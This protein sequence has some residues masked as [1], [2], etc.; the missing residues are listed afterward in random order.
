M[1]QF[2]R[3]AI[4]DWHKYLED[5][6]NSTPVE[7][8]LTHAEMEKK[9][10]YLEA[11]PIEW[12][13]YFFPK[14]ASAE[15]AP[16]QKRAIN[17]IL[18]NPE[19]YEVLSW[20]RELAKSTIAMF[21]IMFLVL[22]GRKHCVIILSATWDNAVK[23]LGHY[24]ANFEANGRI[25][26]FYGTQ[27]TIGHWEKDNLTL[28]NGT[29]FIAIGA[30][31]MP[32][33][34]RSEN[35]RPDI[36]CMDDYDTDEDCRNPETLKKKWDFFEDAVYPTRSVSVNTLILWLGNIIAKDCCI[37]RAG[38]MADNWDIINIRD[39]SGNS[40]W[41]E[42]NTEK[43]IDR[44]LSGI[45][46]AAQQKEYY[47]NPI[48]EGMIFKEMVF[49]KVPPLRKFKFLVIYGDPAPSES[50]KKGTSFKSVW[51]TGFHEG[52][53]YVIKGF[54]DHCLSTEFIYHYVSLLEYVDNK[55]VV[56][57]YMENNKLQDPFFQQVFRPIVLK[58]RKEKNISLYIAPDIE[59]KTD[60]ATR[61]EANL[62]PLNREGALIFNEDEKDN[63]NMQ[64]LRDQFQLFEM[65]L[66]YAADGPDSIEGAQR[67]LRHKRQTM[68]PDI[69]IS[70]D[71]L[72]RKNKFRI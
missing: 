31:N 70:R 6:M 38:K 68:E 18:S 12:I 58:I 25:K 32:R 34:A 42:K 29:S 55:S 50:K 49:G 54:L 66:P 23:L 36:I 37:A 27:Q 52:K 9:R 22:T 4:Q 39:K 13:K 59:R 72:T 46:T 53:L 19:W 28:K 64:E 30:G 40:S 65:Y 5:I 56:Y 44:C 20:S 67:I 17:R 62:E 41:P 14:Y 63:P 1:K 26:A 24:K 3:E 16:F 35:I 2:E 11:H 33:G 45:S 48:T 15:F 47:N 21:I 69:V 10:I 60:K 8:N 57:C 61:I 71:K 7:S 43:D 51:L